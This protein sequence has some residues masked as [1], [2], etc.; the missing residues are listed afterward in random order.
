MREPE[1]AAWKAEREAL[2]RAALRPWTWAALS[3]I[4][5][6]V[7]WSALQRLGVV[8]GLLAQQWLPLALAL[9]GLGAMVIGRSIYRQKLVSR[10]ASRLP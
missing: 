5:S 10:A 4:A 9:L 1:L 8:H 6:A 7:L 3:A 2:K